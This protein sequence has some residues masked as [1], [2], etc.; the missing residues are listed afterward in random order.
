MPAYCLTS[1]N[2]SLAPGDRILPLTSSSSNTLL[3]TIDTTA[4]TYKVTLAEALKEDDLVEV[5]QVLPAGSA[6]PLAQSG[7]CAS[8]PRRVAF[9]F[10]FHRTDLSFVAG[11]LLSNSSS[12]GTTG[13]NFSPQANQFY[14][15]A[16]AD[17]AWR[18]PGYDCIDG[19]QWGKGEYGNCGKKE[20][21]IPGWH[22]DGELPGISTCFS[23]PA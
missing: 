8:V 19:T 18:L 12:G 14:A 11:V 13:A 2:L 21:S 1:D 15:F 16:N 22:T 4:G 5:V 9:P 10:D 20:R 7:H 17:H 6:I 23:R 3:G